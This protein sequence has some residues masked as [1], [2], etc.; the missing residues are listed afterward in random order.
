MRTVCVPENVSQC[1]YMYV[2]QK[3]PVIG[4]QAKWLKLAK[5][6]L[7]NDPP[8]KLSKVQKLSPSVGYGTQM[9]DASCRGL[10]F[11]V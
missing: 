3:M 11:A 1:M 2:V 5:V 6:R 4:L 10:Y 9:F 7:K 8:K